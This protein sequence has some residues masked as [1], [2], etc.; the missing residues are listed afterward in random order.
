MHK[1]RANSFLQYIMSTSHVNIWHIALASSSS[2]KV[3]NI[4]STSHV[5]ISHAING[6]LHQKS[7]QIK[8]KKKTVNKKYNKQRW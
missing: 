5:N 3:L 6:N 4:M 8:R 1:E 7:N 2:T